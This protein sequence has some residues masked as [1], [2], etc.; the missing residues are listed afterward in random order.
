MCGS[1]CG[2]SAGCYLDGVDDVVSVQAGPQLVDGGSVDVL[3]SAEQTS[4]QVEPVLLQTKQVEALDELLQL[5]DDLIHLQK[6]NMLNHDLLWLNPC[7]FPHSYPEAFLL[8]GFDFTVQVLHGAGEASVDQILPHVFVCP[9]HRW[10]HGDLW[11]CRRSVRTTL[12]LYRGRQIK[13]V[14]PSHNALRQQH[15]RNITL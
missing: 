3:Q 14:M 9:L 15:L 8:V 13:E 7:T 1:S 12:P 10:A 6:K 2:L 11:P 4:V 5:I